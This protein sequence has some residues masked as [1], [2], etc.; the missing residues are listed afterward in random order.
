MPAV[1]I[2][3]DEWVIADALTAGLT[4]AGYQVET[5][6]NG[7]IALERLTELRPDVI[8]LDFMM[9]VMN[10]RATLTAIKADQTLREIPV[11]IMTSLPESRVLEQVSGYRGFLSKP[12]TI[13]RALDMLSTVLSGAP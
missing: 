13:M 7:K 1:L 2:I 3:E 11:I 5:A 12:F 4:D 10:G 9:P 6:A 8:L